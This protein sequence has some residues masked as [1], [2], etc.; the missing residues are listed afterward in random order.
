VSRLIDGRPPALAAKASVGH[1]DRAAD[2]RGRPDVRPR[3][4]AALAV[5]HQRPIRL[6]GHGDEE[7]ADLPGEAARVRA[8]GHRAGRAHASPED[9]DARCRRRRDAVQDLRPT[10]VRLLDLRIEDAAR[11]C[12]ARRRPLA[13]Q[14]D[15]ELA[16]MIEGHEGGAWQ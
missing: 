7:E 14:A 11:R 12:V 10:H 4:D 1:L 13:A 2:H 5:A 15:A 8:T 16:S 9:L 6:A 3:H